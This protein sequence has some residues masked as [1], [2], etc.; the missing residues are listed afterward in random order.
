MHT[1]AVTA[2]KLALFFGAAGTAVLA[3]AQSAGAPLLTQLEASYSLTKM[4]FG[5]S[6]VTG[7]GSVYVVHV[8]GLLARAISDHVTPTTTIKDGQ[9]MVATKGISGIFG[10]GG[11]T[12][13]VAQGE[14]FYL[15]GI[16]V[17]NDAIVFRLV[18]L[19][20]HIVVDNDQSE[21]SRF[22]MLIK[23]P[24]TKDVADTLTVAD[25]HHLTDPIFSVEGAPAPA[26]QV[27]LGESEADVEKAFGQPD[28]IVDLG[29]KKVLSYRSLKITLVDNK[30]TDA[31]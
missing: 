25:A 10:T 1:R 21:Q 13:P 7:P 28:R 22:R 19:K 2:L 12:R 9:P 15:V 5:S 23:F 30:V 17:N 3:Q 20:T 14:R 27:Q 4:G 8:D 29:S 16:D 26:P 18:S 6:R 31:E 11:D 24:L